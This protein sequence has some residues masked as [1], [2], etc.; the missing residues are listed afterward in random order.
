M[1]FIWFSDRSTG[2]RAVAEECVSSLKSSEK[3]G[4]KDATARVIPVHNDRTL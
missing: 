2:R 3:E 1:W 4:S